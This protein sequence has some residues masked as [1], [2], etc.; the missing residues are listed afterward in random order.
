MTLDESYETTRHAKPVRCPRC[1]KS[2]LVLMF[3]SPAR[4]MVCPHCHEKLIALRRHTSMLT[5]HGSVA[6]P[7]MR[8]TNP[9][10]CPRCGEAAQVLL[11]DSPLAGMV[12]HRCHVDLIHY[13]EE[14][15]GVIPTAR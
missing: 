5:V 6:T 8:E 10:I 14:V 12:C 9:A 11:F 2:S 4:G 7:G 3:D 15:D 13:R 1:L